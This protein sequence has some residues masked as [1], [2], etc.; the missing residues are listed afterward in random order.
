[1]Q[2]SPNILLVDDDQ[3]LAGITQEYLMAKGLSVHLAHN[4]DDALELFG[5]ENYDICLL[6][7]KMPMKDG[8]GLAEDLRKISQDISIIFLTGQ[9]DKED[10]IRGLLLGADDYITKPFSMEELFLRI[11]NVFRRIKPLSELSEESYKIGSFQ[12]NP[13]SRQL[14]MGSKIQRLSEMEGQLLNLFY[15][16][17][18]KRI[19]RDQALNQIWQDDDRLKSR[20]LS[21]YINKLRRRL[22]ED[23]NVEIINVYGTG[24]QLVI[25]S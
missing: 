16:Q 24:Y 1:M 6:D 17:V 4:A 2:T 7:V 21:V 15:N 14:L 18:S 11:K 19:T 23:P 25:H 9:K 22:K 8:F 12:Y 20:S 10:R 3:N 5:R 13:V